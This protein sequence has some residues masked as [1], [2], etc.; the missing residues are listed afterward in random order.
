M[1]LLLLYCCEPAAA[2]GSPPDKPH[3]RLLSTWC[4]AERLVG[5]WA[6]APTPASSVRTRVSVPVFNDNADYTGRIGWC[7]S[8]THIRVFIADDHAITRD[9]T[10]HLLERE[11]DLR[12]VGEAGDGVETLRLTEALRPDVLLLDLSMPRLDG[13]EVARR[14]LRGLPKTRI[15]ILTGYANQQYAQMAVRLGVSGFLDKTASYREVVAALRAAHAGHVF[16]RTGIAT[17]PRSGAISDGTWPT[18]RELEVLSLV[19]KG[20]RNR[21]IAAQLVTAE[22]TVQFHLG[23]L[24]SKLDASSRTE[25]VH[26]ARQKGWIA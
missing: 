5:E 11:M 12:I 4:H 8:M 6:V 24:F 19:A 17:V 15:V 1:N 25:L 20:H 7:R 2:T 10:R 9:G 21:D 3:V 16:I 18:P 26:L 22:R 13:I 14:V 23:N